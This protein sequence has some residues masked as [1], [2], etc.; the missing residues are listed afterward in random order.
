MAADDSSLAFMV[1]DVSIA[2]STAFGFTTLI[3]DPDGSNGDNM[4]LGAP[5]ASC[6][7]N[8]GWD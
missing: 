7:S 4:G 2:F 5:I 3:P 6:L 8:E 1:P